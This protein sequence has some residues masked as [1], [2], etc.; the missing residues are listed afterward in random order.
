MAIGGV[1]RNRNASLYLGAVVISSFG[2]GAMLLVAGVWVMT[3]T[4]NSALA[5]L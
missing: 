4:D 1:L 3:L 2:S 5:A